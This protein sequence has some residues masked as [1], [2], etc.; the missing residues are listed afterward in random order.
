MR[1]RPFL[2]SCLLPLL[3]AACGSSSERGS[4]ETAGEGAAGGEGSPG[5]T[6]PGD[7][8]R[9]S[10]SAGQEGGVVVLWPRLIGSE[11]GEAAALQ[12]RMNEMASRVLPNR[13]LD[14]RPEPE[15]TCPRSGCAGI[16]L[17]ALLVKNGDAC[18]VVAL[19]GRPGT[20]DVRLVPWAGRMT[21]RRENVGYR[22]PPEDGVTMH[23]FAA[24]A[25]LSTL[26]DQNASIVEAILRDVS[27]QSD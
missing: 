7:D 27:A 25:E 17:G 12:T 24:C 8:P 11:E 2:C 21:L 23:D 6:H 9:I 20:G 15:R 18:A 14:L 1:T 19:I 10:R 13:P 26:L 22:D 16:S 3:L 4:I 5:G